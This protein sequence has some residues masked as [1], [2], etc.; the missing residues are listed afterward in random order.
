MHT[1]RPHRSQFGPNR[2]SPG[3]GRQ[4]AEPRSHQ[5]EITEGGTR[6]LPL[7]L[8]GLRR[9][10]LLGAMGEGAAGSGQRAAIRMVSEEPADARLEHLCRQAPL[11]FW[12]L[13]PL[14]LSPPV[15]DVNSPI[16][17]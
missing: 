10:Q 7:L 5:L 9:A 2:V 11:G 14:H 12:R 17:N 1:D 8:Q 13:F 15:T 16:P 6:S 4:V 3:Q